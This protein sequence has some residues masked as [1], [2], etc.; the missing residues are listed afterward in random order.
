MD[1]SGRTIMLA[2]VMLCA[3]STGLWAQPTPEGLWRTFD[4]RTGRESGSV[5]IQRQGG[6]LIGRIAGTINPADGARTCELCRDDRK[7]KRILG[8]T[9]IRGMRQDGNEWDGGQILDPQTGSVYSCTMRLADS[10]RKLIVRGFL[11]V[12]LL[13]RSQNWLRAR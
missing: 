2:T 6:V 4:D 7:G 1:L 10:G 5:L 3:F 8:L 9:I 12:S 11:G 13:G